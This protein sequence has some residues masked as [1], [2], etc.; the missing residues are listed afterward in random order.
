MTGFSTAAM[1]QDDAVIAEI[2]TVL[3]SKP[4]DLKKALKPFKK[5]MKKAEVLTAMS[6]TFLEMKDTLNAK[7]YVAMA[8]DKNNKYAPA[9]ILLGDITAVGTNGGEAAKNYEQAIYLDPK[10]PVAYYKYANVYAS[11]SSAQAVAKLEDLRAQRPDVSV[12]AQIGHVYYVANQFEQAVESFAKVP[13]GQLEDSYTKE[14]A[15]VL[16]FTQKYDQSLNVVKTGLAANARDGVYNR[17][18]LFN[19]TELKDYA[20][21][22]EAADALFNKSEGAKLSYMDYTYYGN[23]LSGNEQYDKAI[24]MYK[25]ALEQEIDSKDKRAGVYKTLSDAY[26]QIEDFDNAVVTYKEY[27]NLLGTNTATDMAG[28]ANIYVQHGSVLTDSVAKLEKLQQAEMV[29]A[30]MANNP[31]AVEYATFW[32]ARVNTMMDP[33][34]KDALAK[35]HYEKLVE[36]IAPKEEK[37]KSDNA[38][39]I[40]AYRYLGAYYWIVL[41]EKE[42]SDVYWNKILEIDPENEIATQA[43]GAGKKKK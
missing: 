35:P 6:K 28:L 30:E 27:V 36:L 23:A 5:P 20:K 37:S 1:A 24:D 15:M 25:K 8:L 40:E 34:S 26:K 33:D 10:N 13:Q 41:N 43:L 32:R 19:Y 16:Y 31:D 4:A 38:R 12:D 22:L 2:S 14:F 21:A 42:Q 29:Y 3:K 39:L 9:Y 18:A 11:I 7:E 17:L